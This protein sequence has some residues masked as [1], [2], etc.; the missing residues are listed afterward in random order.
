MNLQEELTEPKLLK[1]MVTIDLPIPQGEIM[2]PESQ[3]VPATDLT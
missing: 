2:A 3:V 1:F